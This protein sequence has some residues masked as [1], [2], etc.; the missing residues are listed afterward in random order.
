MRH[1]E[2]KKREQTKLLM[3][4]RIA[5]YSYA[6]VPWKSKGQRRYSDEDVPAAA[7]KIA[8]LLLEMASNER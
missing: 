6:H 7:E 4:D 3:P 2:R 1:D 8:E 5:F